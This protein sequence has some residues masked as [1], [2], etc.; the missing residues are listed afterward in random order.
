[1]LWREIFGVL[2]IV[3]DEVAICR[4]PLYENNVSHDKTK[5]IYC[6]SCMENYQVAGL[7]FKAL[8]ENKQAQITQSD[9]A[10]L[11]EP[12][13]NA[14]I[15]EQ[16][17]LISESPSTIVNLGEWVEQKKQKSTTQA[18]CSCCVAQEQQDATAGLNH[19][20]QSPTKKVY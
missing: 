1:L 11:K 9:Y 5:F 17:T 18:T 7:Q 16:T 13:S 19:T 8:W 3:V 20:E 2:H 10:S 12:S 4:V 14:K 15:V 6:L